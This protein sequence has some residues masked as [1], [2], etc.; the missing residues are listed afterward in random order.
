MQGTYDYLVNYIIKLKFKKG[1]YSS[2]T[3]KQNQQEIYIYI[4]MICIYP[5]LSMRKIKN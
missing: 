4:S 1:R 3:K 2:A 5:Y